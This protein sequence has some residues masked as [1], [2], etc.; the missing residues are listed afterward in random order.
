MLAWRFAKRYTMYGP[1]ICHH[2]CVTLMLAALS[3]LDDYNKTVNDD[4]LNF[5]TWFTSLTPRLSGGMEISSFA[6]F[7]SLKR[8]VRIFHEPD[9]LSCWSSSWKTGLY[10]SGDCVHLHTYVFFFT[11]LGYQEHSSSAVKVCSW[12]TICKLKLQN[13]KEKVKDLLQSYVFNLSTPWLLCSSGKTELCG[14]KLHKKD[15]F[16]LDYSKL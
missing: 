16:W 13:Y 7:T 12:D 5:R 3:V 4:L 10:L 15:S 9:H 14:L 8:L 11:P 1:I 6:R 2:Y